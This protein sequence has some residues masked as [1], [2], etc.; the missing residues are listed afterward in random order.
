MSMYM[1]RLTPPPTRTDDHI[2]NYGT[3][4]NDCEAFAVEEIGSKTKK[5]HYQS[6]TS[7]PFKRDTLRKR[8]TK[9]KYDGNGE[10]SITPTDKDDPGSTGIP[11]DDKDDVLAYLCKGSAR[12]TLPVVILNTMNISEADILAYHERYWQKHD[13]I[14]DSYRIKTRVVEVVQEGGEVIKVTTKKYKQESYRVK[15]YK[16]FIEFLRSHKDV[17]HGKYK[18]AWIARQFFGFMGIQPK[19]ELTNW[20]RGT[21]FSAQCVLLNGD[22]SDE[23]EK[24]ID[25]WIDQI[26]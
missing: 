22:V 5:K 13:S 25:R 26:L 17:D 24:S 7:I 3:I 2:A 8:F 11:L 10:Y 20:I 16:E 14:I 12:G 4:H 15:V 6:L 23:A 18:L 9:M 1:T 21:I 19:P